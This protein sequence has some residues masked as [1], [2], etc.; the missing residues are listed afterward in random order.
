VIDVLDLALARLLDDVAAP[1]AVREADVSFETPERAYRP[2]EPTINLFLAEV[3]EDVEARNPVPVRTIGPDGVTEHRA[4]LRLDCR[5]LLTAW[6]PSDDGAA[7][8]VADEHR[9]LGATLA[10]VAANPVLQPSLFGG[11]ADS[12]PSPVRFGVAAALPNRELG[13]LWTALGAQP[14]PSAWLSVRIALAAAPGVVVGPPVTDVAVD[15]G[16]PDGARLDNPAHMVGGRVLDDE[17]PIRGASVLVEATGRRVLTDEDGVF[18]VPLRDGTQ[19]LLVSAA[20]H[21]DARRTVNVPPLADDAPDIELTR[22][23]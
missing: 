4:P 10:W 5:Y 20:G 12:Q 14:R 19:R 7:R 9:L 2:A 6:H 18:R 15:L 3:R 1:E 21:V 23:T 22:Q 16:E 17:G 13:E 11:A 8:R